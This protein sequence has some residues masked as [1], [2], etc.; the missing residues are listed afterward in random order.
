MNTTLVTSKQV[1]PMILTSRYHGT[2]PRIDMVR[3][4]E[5][6]LTYLASQLRMRIETVEIVGRTKAPK[7]Y[8]LI[9]NKNGKRAYIGNNVCDAVELLTEM[10]NLHDLA[11]EANV[12]AIAS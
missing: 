5:K 12:V 7:G 1:V 9:N 2:R 10:V 4:L 6:R 11:Q 8:F 3:R